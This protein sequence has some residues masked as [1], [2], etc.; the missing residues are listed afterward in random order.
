MRRLAFVVIAAC[1]SPVGPDVTVTTQFA[2]TRMGGNQPSVLDPL[3]GQVIDVE[4]VLDPVVVGHG[5]QGTCTASAFAM[6]EPKR[7]ARGPTAE[8]VQR[9]ILDRLIDWDVRLELCDDAAQSTLTLESV[10]DPL[11]LSFGCL[12]VPASAHVYDSDHY[13][14]LTSFTATA[15]NSIVLDVVFNRDIGGTG[16]PMTV[17]TG[18]E[19]I[20]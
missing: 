12:G 7:T 2:V 9:E 13:P 8:L 10:I 1:G 11:N 3:V 15:C 14:V 20:P 4:L 17:V 16:F 18:S 19:R 6:S 5:D